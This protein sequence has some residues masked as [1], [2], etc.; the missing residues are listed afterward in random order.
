MTGSRIV[1]LS[2]VLALV[3]AA[4]LGV[5]FTAICRLVL[6]CRRRSGVISADSLQPR[7]PLPKRRPKGLIAIV[8]CN[9][10]HIARI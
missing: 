10:S 3:L 9:I 2:G 5:F 8:H 6:R 1:A 4:V 7:V